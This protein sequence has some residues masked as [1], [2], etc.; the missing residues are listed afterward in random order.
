DVYS[1]IKG[2]VDQFDNLRTFR[3]SFHETVNRSILANS[4]CLETSTKYA[5]PGTNQQTSFAESGRVE[6]GDPSVLEASAKTHER[7]EPVER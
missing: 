2:L 7:D 1:L 6:N 5:I 3:N 4:L